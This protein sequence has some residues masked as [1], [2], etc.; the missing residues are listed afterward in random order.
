MRERNQTIITFAGFRGRRLTFSNSG[1]HYPVNAYQSFLLA[2][3]AVNE[4][5]SLSAITGRCPGML[6]A[7]EICC[8]GGAAALA[9]RSAGLGVVDASDLNPDAVEACESNAVAN[10]LVL[11]ACEVR[12]CLGDAAFRLPIYD[13]IACNPPCR[14]EWARG[15]HRMALSDDWVEGSVDGG[16]LGDQ[17]ALAVIERASQALAPGG[18]L[19]MVVTSTQDFASIFKRLNALGVRWWT[20]AAS[21]IA[22]PYVPAESQVSAE[23]IRLHEE[24]RIIAWDGGDGWFWR[25]SWVV[26]VQSG[27]QAGAGASD[28][29]GSPS[30]RNYGYETQS[31]SY[32]NAVRY[33]EGVF[34]GRSEHNG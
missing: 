14:P 29:S 13:I 21:P 16:K 28:A 17:F 8:G 19:V 4:A 10:G 3:A 23:L 11:D 18:I 2:T 32:L 26:V 6:R 33:F 24:R 5:L 27:A 12:D 22:Q 15:M 30:F 31:R 25:L 1:K 20:S 7:V 34:R 9:L